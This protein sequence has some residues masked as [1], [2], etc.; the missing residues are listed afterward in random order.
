MINQRIFLNIL[1]DEQ[2]P[3]PGCRVKIENRKDKFEA[4]T[5]YS[6]IVEFLVPLGVYALTLEHPNFKKKIYRMT[7]RDGF[8]FTRIILQKNSYSIKQEEVKNRE[9]MMNFNENRQKDRN[10]NANNDYLSKEAT[11]NNDLRN[12]E[13]PT[14]KVKDEQSELQE[15]LQGEH[16]IEEDN[17]NI[18]NNFIKTESFDGNGMFGA[19]GN[20]DGM[21]GTT[22]EDILNGAKAMLQEIM[23]FA[24]NIDLNN[25]EYKGQGNLYNDEENGTVNM[26]EENEFEGEWQP[27]RINTENL[28]SNYDDKTYD[29]YEYEEE[30][31]EPMS[32][33]QGQ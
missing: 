31:Y 8:S 15:N 1:D 11:F 26:H 32:G 25:Q 10:L 13:Y 27:E 4:D 21:T 24:E 6:G 5:D 2:R 23:E 20:F 16:S 30:F 28:K 22:F 18:L 12:I 33:S 14:Q 17:K 29:V 19:M 9:H 7:L 3:I